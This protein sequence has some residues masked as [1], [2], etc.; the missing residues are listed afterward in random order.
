[1]KKLLLILALALGAGMPITASAAT[2]PAGVPSM[3]AANPNLR[4]HTWY[5]GKNMHTIVYNSVTGEVVYMSIVDENG[6]IIWGW[7]PN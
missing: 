3:L 1:M 6:D 5:E 4:V 7:T 2:P